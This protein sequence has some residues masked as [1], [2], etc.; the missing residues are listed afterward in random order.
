M[1]N[2]HT[3]KAKHFRKRL[4]AYGISARCRAFTSCG[5]KYVQIN[6]PAYE[7]EFTDQEQGQILIIAKTI[8]LTLSR[9]ME[10]NLDQRTYSKCAD[11]VLA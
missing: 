7:T 9:G 3:A 4:S 8:G 6:V 1:T 2:E 10:I 11:F 5:V